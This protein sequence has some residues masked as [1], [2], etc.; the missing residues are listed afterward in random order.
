MGL[1][2]D[3]E[4]EDEEC[5]RDGVDLGLRTHGDTGIG[6][7]A[8]QPGPSSSPEILL[9]FGSA[10]GAAAFSLHGG[11][12]AGAGGSGHGAGGQSLNRH[13][14]SAGRDA[15]RHVGVINAATAAGGMPRR[16]SW[17]GGMSTSDVGLDNTGP[18][19]D[20][21]GVVDL[22]AGRGG[23]L[24]GAVGVGVGVGAAASGQ[25]T[26]YICCERRADAVLMECGHGGTCF[27][28][29]QQLASIPPAQCP[30]CR[31][32]I[33]EVLM[34]GGI[35]SAP[36]GGSL[37]GGGEL[38][39]PDEPP[40]TAAVVGGISISGCAA[41]AAARASGPP[42]NPASAGTAVGRVGSGTFRRFSGPDVVGASA[43]V[44]GAVGQ[45]GVQRGRAVG[46][47]GAGAGTGAGAREAP[48][49]GV[50]ESA[51]REL[52]AQG[53]SEDGGWLDPV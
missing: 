35:V 2:I 51:R 37:A 50:R 17:P 33:Q 52:E 12:A 31:K 5:D 13:R 44:A 43:S 24:G 18:R 14:W 46:D 10:H 32:T 42:L 8:S 38:K 15:I 36:S 39:A 30:V 9:A 47:A 1:S 7:N 29:A 23:G 27:E 53:M 16:V 25:S 48:A 28:C 34:F 4:D 40:A 22:E 3:G 11:L 20:D 41:P 49:P 45:G 19:G 21:E 26:C 6:G